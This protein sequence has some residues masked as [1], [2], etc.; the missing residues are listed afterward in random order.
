MLGLAPGAT[1]EEVKTAY[2]DLAQ[3]WHPDRFPDNERLHQKAVRNQQLINEAYAVLRELEPPPSPPPPPPP[4]APLVH[5]HLTLGQRISAT[6]GIGDAR[7]P[8]LLGRTLHVFHPDPKY[9]RRRRMR[10]PRR[11]IIGFLLLAAA[12]LATL[13]YEGILAF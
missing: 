7:H 2:R 9:R 11:L 12:A 1:P 13:W 3:V 8:G 10:R 4:E 5:P 6:L